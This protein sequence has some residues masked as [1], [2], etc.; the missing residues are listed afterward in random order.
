MVTNPLVWMEMSGLDKEQISKLKGIISVYKNE[1]KNFVDAIITP[2]GDKPDGMSYT[3]FNIEGK[4][5]SYLIL[6]K[7]YSKDDEYSYNLDTTIGSFDILYKNT[8]AD[9]DIKPNGITVKNMD[10]CSYLFIKYTK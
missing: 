4:D 1:R 3:G 6:L 10:K 9:I 7:E 2:I 5:S 8:T